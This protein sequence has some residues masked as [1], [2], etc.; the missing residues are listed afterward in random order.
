MQLSAL[1]VQNDSAQ[2]VSTDPA[3]QSSL[4][5]SLPL[6]AGLVNGLVPFDLVALQAAI[7]RFSA[8]LDGL[9]GDL[10]DSTVFA[11]LA[12][13]LA[14]TIVLAG[15]AYFCR[16][17]QQHAALEQEDPGLEWLR[18]VTLVSPGEE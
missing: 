13:W 4:A 1:T 18:Y 10:A 8:Q 17:R 2:S 11:E 5:S 16:P 14:G 12:P 7:D 6:G 9:A 3:A 15:T